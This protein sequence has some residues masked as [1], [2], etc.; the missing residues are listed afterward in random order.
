MRV[1]LTI[2]LYRRL[3][4]WLLPFLVLL[5][6]SNP[7]YADCQATVSL[8]DFGQLDLDKGSNV[9]GEVIVTCDQPAR[10]NL[11]LSAGLGDFRLRKMLG[12]DG[13]EL[14]YNLFV[15]PGRRSIWGDGVSGGTQTIRGENDGRR[16]SIVPIYGIV[17]SRQS[18][19]TGAYRDDLLVTVEKL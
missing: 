2:T 8:V 12:S 7:A 14:L 3:A 17:P 4:V 11:A 18:V 19:L 13:G 16:P 1:N 9:N 15:D 6:V 10:F 5:P